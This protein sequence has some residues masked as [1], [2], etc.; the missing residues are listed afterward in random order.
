[1][2]YTYNCTGI[3]N[4]QKRVKLKERRR[5]EN[6]VPSRQ[7]TDERKRVQENEERGNL[8]DSNWVTW[9]TQYL[10]KCTNTQASMLMF[11]QMHFPPSLP[12]CTAH[13]AACFQQPELK[14]WMEKKKRINTS[15]TNTVTFLR[16][17]N[18]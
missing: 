4:S 14:T 1:M 2:L 17:T 8:F 6:N 12:S 10:T 3:I 5:S 9:V 15:R 18:C 7:R 11:I 13:A 16:C